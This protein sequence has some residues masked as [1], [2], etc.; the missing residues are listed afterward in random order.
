MID[1]YLCEDDVSQLKYLA[2]LIQKYVA[3]QHLE[4]A[5]VSARD[6]PNDT[7]IDV[8][9]NNYNP[10]LFFLDVELKGYSMNG[11]ELCRKLKEQN[12]KFFFVFLTSKNELAYKVFEYE[13]NVL[14]YVIKEPKYFLDETLH[15]DLKERLDR[16]FQK[17]E[18]IT[19]ETKDVIWV[20]CGSRK[21]E[22]EVDSIIYIQ[23]V[24]GTHQLEIVTYNRRIMVHNSL[25]H[26]KEMLKD[27][28][29]EVN[30][31]CLV[32]EKKIKEIDRK[33]DM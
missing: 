14:D 3:E 1:I 28:I 21:V 24:K 7:L 22:I 19:N 27:K 12:E 8:E 15:V 10:S 13:L 33:K 32:M 31:S 26:I 9:N 6:N 29:I 17:I 23:S 25:E 20:E 30:K 2:D 18:Q 5:V 16:I 11:F 4:A